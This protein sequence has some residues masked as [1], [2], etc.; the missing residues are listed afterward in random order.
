MKALLLAAFALWAPLSWSAPPTAPRPFHADSL[1]S[2]RAEH[3]GRPFVLALWSL[4]CAPCHDELKLW[5]SLRQRY[6]RVALVLVNTD[7]PDEHAAATTALARLGLPAGWAFDDEMPERLRYSIDP[8]WRGELPRH[9]FHDAAHHR[10][11]RS[12][13]PDPAWLEGWLRRHS[14]RR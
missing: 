8:G 10:E 1:A 12:G 2:I 14:P 3:A 11:A 13:K 4:Y 6:P 7:A 9:Y 5:A